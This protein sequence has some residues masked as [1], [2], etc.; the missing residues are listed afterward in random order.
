MLRWYWHLR[1]RSMCL[2]SSRTVFLCYL[3]TL[4]DKAWYSSEKLKKQSAFGEEKLRL[5]VYPS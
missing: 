2:A 5:I 3:V 4:K 1:R